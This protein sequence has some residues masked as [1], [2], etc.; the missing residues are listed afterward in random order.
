MTYWGMIGR[1]GN[2]V[3]LR[4]ES[5][6]SC[7]EESSRERERRVRWPKAGKALACSE[8]AQVAAAQEVG[9]G[10]M[11]RSCKACRFIGKPWEGFRQRKP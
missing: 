2:L 11:D 9:N 3:E 10:G 7:L 5:G 1:E 8:K 6:R 4:S